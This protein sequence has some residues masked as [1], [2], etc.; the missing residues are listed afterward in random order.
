[1]VEASGKGTVYSFTE[2][3]RSPD[4]DRFSTPYT[5]ALVR[6]EEGPLLLTRLVDTPDPA[7]DMAVRV[8][9][10][11]IDDRQLPVFRPIR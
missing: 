4:R 7:C 10:R 2:V 1:M 9:W 6:L 11:R 5:I 3:H 8:E